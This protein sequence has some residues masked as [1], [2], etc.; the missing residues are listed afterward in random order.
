MLKTY[1]ATKRVSNGIVSGKGLLFLLFTCVLWPY[2]LSCKFYFSV[3]T[4]NFSWIRRNVERSFFLSRD[5]AYSHV[6]YIRISKPGVE[7]MRFPEKPSF[8]V[9]FLR[10]HLVAGE[11]S[12]CQRGRRSGN[13]RQ[14][15]IFTCDKKLL[16]G[17]SL[18]ALH[19]LFQD[20]NKPCFC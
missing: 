10:E 20:L 5:F 16:A 19:Y 8:P 4:S 12:L 1:R 17:K 15:E 6:I 13:W 2:H 14:Q 9:G 3:F 18:L 7:M 11:L